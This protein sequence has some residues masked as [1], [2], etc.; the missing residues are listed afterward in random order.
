MRDTSR[1]FS[2]CICAAVLCAFLGTG[3][4]ADAWDRRPSSPLATRWRF[5][6][7]VARREP[8]CS[9]WLTAFLIATSSKSGP[10]GDSAPR[11]AHDRA[12]LPPGSP[13]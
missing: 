10:E 3:A 7:K 9:N 11:H 12:G 5:P 13:G 6:G 2:L 4:N 8:T 1:T